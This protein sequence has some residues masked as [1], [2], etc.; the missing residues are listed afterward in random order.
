MDVRLERRENLKVEAELISPLMGSDRWWGDELRVKGR[1]LPRGERCR[2]SRG[3][4]DDRERLPDVKSRWHKSRLL[5]LETV[6]S[7]SYARS[8]VWREEDKG[9]ACENWLVKVFETQPTALKSNLPYHADLGRSTPLD[10]LARGA[11]ARVL[12]NC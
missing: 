12:V 1:R 5:D 4:N 2:L 10:C 6:R 7:S 8:V 11:T 9:V 3:A